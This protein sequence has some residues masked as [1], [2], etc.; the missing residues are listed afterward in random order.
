M[1]CLRLMVVLSGRVGTKRS[2]MTLNCHGTIAIMAF[3]NVIRGE[4][5]IH[6]KPREGVQLLTRTHVVYITAYSM[7]ILGIETQSTV[8]QRTQKIETAAPEDHPIKKSR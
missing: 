3:I 1:P 7:G 8:R 6:I 5:K 2:I 4:S